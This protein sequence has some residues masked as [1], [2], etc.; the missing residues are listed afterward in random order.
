MDAF[1]SGLSGLQPAGFDRAAIALFHGFRKFHNP[2][3]NLSSFLPLAQ[4]LL[5]DFDEIVRAGRQPEEVFASLKRWEDTGSSFADFMDEEQKELMKRFSLL[6]T[7]KVS[8]T[9]ARFSRLWEN[10]PAV[11]SYMEEVLLNENLG[12]SGMAYRLAEKKVLSGQLPAGHQFVFA[13]FSGLSRTET[14]MMRHLGQTGKASFAWDILPWYSNKPGHEVNRVFSVLRKVPEFQA[15]IQD[16][17]KKCN[18]EIKPIITEVACEGLSGMGLW[19]QNEAKNSNESRVLIVSNPA[20]VQVLAKTTDQNDALPLHLSMGFPLAY[21][22]LARWV[23]RIVKW[24]SRENENQTEL[25]RHLTADHYFSLL[26]PK[27]NIQWRNLIEN[28]HAPGLTEIKD[29]DLPV[30]VFARNAKDWVAQFLHWL[31]GLR[32]TLSKD[33]LDAAGLEKLIELLRLLSRASEMAGLDFDFLV[34]HQLLPS[35]LNGYSIALE[36][37]EGPALRAMGLFESRNLDFDKVI[38][39]PG[40][41]GLFPQSGISQSFLPDNVRRAF[42]LPLKLQAVEEE[43]YRFYRLC[44]RA[45][46]VIFLT[47]SGDGTR[48][49]R[50]LDQIEFGSDFTYKKENQSFSSAIRLAPEI[51]I[52]KLPEHLERIGQYMA[53][54]SGLDTI[55]KL[56]PSSLHALLVCPLRFHYQKVLGLKEPDQYSDIEMSPLD[57]GNWIHESIQFL[58]K[59]VAGHRKTIKPE[60]YDEMAQRWDEIQHSVW[61]ELEKGSPGPLTM[62]PVEMALGK[63]MA[64]RFFRLM[65]SHVPHRWLENEYPVPNCNIGRGEK[66]WNV[67]GRVDIILEEEFCFRVIDLKTGGF[68]EKDK[69]LLVLDDDGNPDESKMAGFKDYFQMLT[70]NRIVSED[71]KFKGKPVR[72]C[73]LYLSSP[74]PAFADP[75]AKLTSREEE[76][77]F[78]RNFENLLLDKLETLVNPDVP[79]LQ[80]EDASHCTYCGFNAMCRR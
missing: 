70:Y 64:N 10:L 80:T 39:A 72:S 6:F 13:G 23:F 18:T 20:L 47:T 65:K 31:P 60:E 50:Y 2:N 46:E 19:L 52:E 22:A 74:E 76:L 68:K 36:R 34:L 11:F 40:D 51:K 8:E 63:I 75:F 44:H 33:P 7:G 54:E 14:S 57:F 67:S 35:A 59:E 71:P 55:K 41:E 15:S 58:M 9:K 28:N 26:L 27:A 32:D 38:I 25:F 29:L 24:V 1:V 56:S 30:W 37:G 5:A 21:T 3:E 49:T 4:V 62:Y 73:L 17:E 53:N 77:D 12:T 42:G 79:V 61:K 45:T 16:W 69:V 43:A 78:F 66:W 48:R